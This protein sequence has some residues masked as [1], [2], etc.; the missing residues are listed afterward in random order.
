MHPLTFAIGNP[1]KWAYRCKACRRKS[2]AKDPSLACSAAVHTAAIEQ[3]HPALASDS[4]NEERENF[5]PVSD[6]KGYAGCV[7]L[8]V[9]GRPSRF[10]RFI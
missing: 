9:G 2:Q 6:I 7:C 1:H 5:N 10:S 3:T 8:C 4:N